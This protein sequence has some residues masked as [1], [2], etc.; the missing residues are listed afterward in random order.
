MAL[1]TY[2]WIVG[3]GPAP[4]IAPRASRIARVRCIAVDSIADA[5]RLNEFEERLSKGRTSRLRAVRTIGARIERLEVGTGARDR[6]WCTG[7]DFRCR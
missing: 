5:Q 7:I 4:G 6:G 1:L 3:L 2:H